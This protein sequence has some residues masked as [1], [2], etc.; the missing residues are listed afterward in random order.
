MSTTLPITS[1]QQQQLIDGFNNAGKKA[2]AGTADGIQDRFLKL[3]VTQMKNQD[4]LNPTDN[5]QI[6]SQLA[7]ISTVNGIDKLNTALTTMS[8]SFLAAQQLQASGMIGHLVLAAGT[9]IELQKGLGVGGI[10]LTQPAD[11]VTVNVMSGGNVV[12]TIHMNAQ[13]AGVHNFAWDGSTDA[14]GTAPDGKYTFQVTALQNGKKIDVQP[15]AAGLV[16]SVSLFNNDLQLNTHGLG[17][18][19]A[20]QIKQIL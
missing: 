3:L 12:K 19:P 16:Q 8:T 14:K 4:P 15:L 17:S 7:Q 6:T 11:D 13:E 1:Q 20:G 5:A 2:A 9:N 18:V 10:E